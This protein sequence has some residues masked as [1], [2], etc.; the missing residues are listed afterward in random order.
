MHVNPFVAVRG[1]AVSGRQERP[2]TGA[3]NALTEFAQPIA[4]FLEPPG[5]GRINQ[6][7]R[8]RADV[9][10][11]IAIAPGGLDEKQDAVA[12]G[13]DGAI[14]LPSPSPGQRRA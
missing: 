3:I 8:P 7:I 13:F 11:A 10:N 14:R 12:Q 1:D 4:D 6:A 2:A 9:E 5:L